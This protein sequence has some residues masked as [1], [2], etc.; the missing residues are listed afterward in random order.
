MCA[1]DFAILVQVL[2][3]HIAH[4]SRTDILD[5]DIGALTALGGRRVGRALEVSIAGEAD[6]GQR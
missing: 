3:L 2:D 1:N 5:G 4:R 6:I